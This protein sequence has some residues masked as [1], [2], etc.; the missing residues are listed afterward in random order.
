[1]M[2]DEQVLASDGVTYVVQ[3]GDTVR[4]PVRPFTATIQTYLKH[5]HDRGFHEAPRPLGYDDQGRE[6][7]SFVE[8]DVPQEPLPDYACTD[9]VLVPLGRLIRRLHDAAA[10]F[11]PPVDAVWGGIPGTPAGVVPLFDKPELIAHQ[12][13][14]PRQ[15]GLSRRPAR[16]VHRLRPLAPNDARRRPRQRH[17]LVDPAH[18]SKRQATS[19]AGRRCAGAGADPGRCVRHDRQSSAPS[20]SRPP[21]SAPQTRCRRCTPAAQ[22]DPVF[23]RWWYGGLEHKLLQAQKWL[24]TEAPHIDAVLRD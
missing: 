18:A 23:A 16:G 20:S 1:M 5:L 21:C 24:A 7:L 19:H 2:D 11:T 8:G 22:A 10:D 12:D 6:V 13:Y 15:R 3:V 14:C 17:V 9:D 4:R